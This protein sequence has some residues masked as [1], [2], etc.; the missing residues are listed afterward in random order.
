MVIN[1]MRWLT[2]LTA[3]AL[4][5]GL[6]APAGAQELEL[7]R[8]VAVINDEI[9]LASELD[10]RMLQQTVTKNAAEPRKAM[11]WA[12]I[13][14]RLLAQRARAAS[15]TT[16]DAEIDAALEEIRRRNQLTQD[17]LLAELRK[18][19]YSLDDYRESVRRQLEIFRIIN[20]ELRPRINITDKD[21]KD[22]Y[23][24][25]VAAGDL[26]AGKLDESKERLRAELYGQQ[27]D[28]A[29]D[30]WLV[31]LRATAFIDIRLPAEG[32]SK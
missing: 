24:K 6:A 23:D 4:V 29:R 28:L 16:S 17:Q 31:Q 9:V 21:V 1:P 27:I 7:D 26:P 25:R 13:D 22:L 15:I 14:E 5:A 30:R 2:E 8:V 19:G 12:M 18:Q 10:R 32:E 11:L 20:L 3:M